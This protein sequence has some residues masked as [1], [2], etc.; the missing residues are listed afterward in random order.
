MIGWWIGIAQQTPEERD[1][2]ADKKAAIIANWEAGTGG[3]DWLEK[4][5]QKGKATKLSHNGYPCR[6]VATA[7]DVLPLIVN[8]PPAHSGPTIIGDDYVTPGGWIGSIEFNSEKIAACAP[9]QILTID[10]WDLD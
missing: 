3:L 9:D 8:G 6:Y 7:R 1:G 10:A 2:A 4:L 5:V